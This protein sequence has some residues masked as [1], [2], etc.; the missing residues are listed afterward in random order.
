MDPHTVL[1]HVAG[2]PAPPNV[3]LVICPSLP[4]I[5][6]PADILQTTRTGDHVHTVESLTGDGLC[7]GEASAREDGRVDDGGEGGLCAQLAG[8]AWGLV[9][10]SGRNLMVWNG[11]RV[12]SQGVGQG[13]KLPVGGDQRFSRKKN[14]R[15]RTVS[16]NWVEL[17]NHLIQVG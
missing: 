5:I 15:F 7:Q 13:G 3:G 9:E 8:A 6:C 14:R 11:E 17:V 12:A 1:G 10:T 2:Q 4:W 16:D